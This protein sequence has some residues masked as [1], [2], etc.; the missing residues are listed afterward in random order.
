MVDQVQASEGKWLEME[1]KLSENTKYHS[2]FLI[3]ISVC[4][5]SVF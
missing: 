1:M 4:A 5:P 3:C 2:L